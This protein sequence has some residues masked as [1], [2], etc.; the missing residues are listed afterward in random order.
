MAVAERLKL[1]VSS[2]QR[3]RLAPMRFAKS[4]SGR[5]GSIF[6]RAAPA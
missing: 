3:I 4:E 1:W 6:P 2:D 5:S